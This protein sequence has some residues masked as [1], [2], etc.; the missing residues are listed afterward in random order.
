MTTFKTLLTDNFDTEV[1]IQGAR[2]QNSNEDIA[3]VVFL[4]FDN[5]NSNC[6]RMAEIAMRDNYGAPF[7]NGYGNL[8]FKTNGDGSNTSNLSDRMVI[9]MNGNIGINIGQPSEK[10]NVDG[11]AAVTSNIYSSNIFASNIIYKNE[12][13][14]YPLG[15]TQVTQSVYSKTFSWIYNNSSERNI[16]QIKD[17]GVRSYIY[18]PSKSNISYSYS[19]RIYDSTTNKVLG[20]ST[21][22]NT[23]PAINYISLG[24]NLGSNDTI[25]ELHTKKESN[26]SYYVNIDGVIVRYVS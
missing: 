23:T 18:T 25:L 14:F 26:D 16:R 9:L 21:L 15:N 11:N 24:S 4:N 12:P 2:S 6:Y 7:Q 13:T 19:M 20:S 3:S 5:D 17:V 22:S 8:V 1:R 10:F